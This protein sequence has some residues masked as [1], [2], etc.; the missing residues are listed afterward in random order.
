MTSVQPPQ[1]I[2]FDC[3][4]TLLLTSGLHFR[5]ISAA[6]ADQGGHMPHDWYMARSG[7]G[8]RDLFAQFA[9]EFAVELDLPRIAADS[10]ARTVALSSAAVEN[11]S[12][13]DVARQAAGRV[14]IAVV[15]NS[16]AAIANAFLLQTALRD[17]FACIVTCDDAARP[18][19]DPDLYLL[20]A[21]RLGVA[22]QG[23]LVLEDS[24]QGIQAARSAGMTWFDVR[25][26]D[27]PQRS[28]G[29]VNILATCRRAVA[30]AR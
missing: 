27:W 14:P 18:K 13:A 21:A 19:P 29:L 16:E 7:L 10:I 28:D 17:L 6:V 2:L 25:S 26:P 20:A 8:R 30:S 4:G 15:T 9:A 3:D 5:A 23:C 12:V 11:P 24:D 22:P 1:A